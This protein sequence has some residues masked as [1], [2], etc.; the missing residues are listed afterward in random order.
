MFSSAFSRAVVNCVNFV[1]TCFIESAAGNILAVRKFYEEALLMKD[2]DH[3][4]VLRLIG[5]V[6]GDDSLPLVVLP[7][8]QN[9]DLLTYIRCGEN[10]SLRGKSDLLVIYLQIMIT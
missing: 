8:M 6:Q 10:V 9:G 2:F 3:N 7:F 5:V 1:Y 4:H